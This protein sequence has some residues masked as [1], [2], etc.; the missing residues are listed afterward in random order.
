MVKSLKIIS[1]QDARKGMMCAF[2]AYEKE[3]IPTPDDGI[4]GGGRPLTISSFKKALISL[5]QTI[6]FIDNWIQLFEGNYDDRI[7]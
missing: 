6:N 4:S 2:N 7:E 5:G 3:H 1:K